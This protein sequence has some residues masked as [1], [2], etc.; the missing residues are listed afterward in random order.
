[1]GSM[2]RNHRIPFKG[3]SMWPL[4]VENDRL[5][6]KYF[7]EPSVLCPDLLGKVVLYR[8]GPEWVA[9]RVL[10]LDQRLICKGDWS[11]G[12]T[13]AN[14]LKVWGV[15]EAVEKPNQ[16]IIPLYQNLRINS[17]VSFFSGRHLSEKKWLR[18]GAKGVLYLINN[19]Q[20]RV[21]SKKK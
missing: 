12:V 3:K 14:N 2:N 20:R 16:K 15:V 1:M 9:H 7:S 19:F 5:I 13:S 10:S 11:L 6:V 4:F 17:W 18:W 8:E 21:L